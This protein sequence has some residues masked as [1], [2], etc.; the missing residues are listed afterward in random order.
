MDYGK[1]TLDEIKKGYKYDKEQ[2]AFV[3]YVLRYLILAR[4]F[5]L[6]ETFL[7]LNLR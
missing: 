4:C 7:W 5:K 1:M 3:E 2:D 6:R